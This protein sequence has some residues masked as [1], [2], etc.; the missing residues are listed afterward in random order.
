MSSTVMIPSRV[1][2]SFSKA[3]F[4]MSCRDR[5]I[6]G[7]KAII[8]IVKGMCE[9]NAKERGRIELEESKIGRLDHKIEKL[10]IIKQVPGV[11]S[12]AGLGLLVGINLGRPAKPVVRALAEGGGL[13]ASEIA[14]RAA[15]LPPSVSRIIAALG[16][17]GLLTRSKDASDAR[18]AVIHLTD[19]GAALFKRVAPRSEAA[20]RRLEAEFGEENLKNLL[21][22]HFQIPPYFL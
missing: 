16:D 7:R 13:D 10:T 6:A 8:E 9:Q 3:L 14:E 5:D 22:Q 4:T 1:L 2:S 20:Y 19:E 12:T 21:I 17:R 11:E 18:R 15:I